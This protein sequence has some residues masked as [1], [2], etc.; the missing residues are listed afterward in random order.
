MT[1]IHYTLKP[2]TV[3]E[4]IVVPM[5]QPLFPQAVSMMEKTGFSASGIEPSITVYTLA[6][7]IAKTKINRSLTGK[8]C[9][10]IYECKG[11]ILAVA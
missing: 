5:F 4:I 9:H 2:E 7:C 6:P 8:D 3:L 1:V 11:I 10:I